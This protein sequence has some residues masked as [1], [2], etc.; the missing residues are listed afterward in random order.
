M[1]SAVLQ[2]QPPAKT[3]EQLMV[4]LRTL[5]PALGVREAARQIG[6]SENTALSWAVRYEMTSN[7]AVKR[8]MDSGTTEGNILKK[9]HGA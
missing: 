1:E 7:P 9:M 3:R 8:A 2:E 4:E 5:I 6:I